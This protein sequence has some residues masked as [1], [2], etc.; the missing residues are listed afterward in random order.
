MDI[1][2]RGKALSIRTFNWPGHA[3]HHEII[4]NILLNAQ[5]EVKIKSCGIIPEK[6]STCE[7]HYNV[8]KHYN[9]EISSREMYIVCEQ[10]R[11][12]KSAFEDNNVDVGR[13][14]HSNEIFSTLMKR[15]RVTSIQE[16]KESLGKNGLAHANMQSLLDIYRQAD[17]QINNYIKIH[18]DITFA[19]IFNDFRFLMHI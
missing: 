11:T 18:G 7:L 2:H 15:H 13:N 4:E 12:S 6:T 10:C 17:R 19:F 1:M 3:E 9:R 8:E 5:Y 16:I 14:Y